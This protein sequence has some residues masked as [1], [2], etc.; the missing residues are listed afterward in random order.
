[1]SD[2]LSGSALFDYLTTAE[3]RPAM[4]FG[5]NSV[6]DVRRHLDG[7]RAHRRLFPDDDDFAEHFFD[8]FHVFVGKHLDDNRTIG[9]NGLIRENA[10]SDDERFQMFM[11]LF[12]TFASDFCTPAR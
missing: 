9:W 3:K 4:Y 7:W 2:R 10:P 12:R 8:G 11:S 5:T 6:D 1:M